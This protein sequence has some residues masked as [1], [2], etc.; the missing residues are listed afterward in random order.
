MRAPTVRLRI[1]FSDY[2]SGAIGCNPDDLRDCEPD[3]NG[4]AASCSDAE[5]VEPADDASA[6]VGWSGELQD[7]RQRETSSVER[8]NQVAQQQAQMR[9]ETDLG[10]VVNAI[11]ESQSK[12][13]LHCRK[14]RS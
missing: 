1:I 12:L 9:G 13:W 6:K 8:L 4:G 3:R 2:G 14:T 7:S 10:P 5:S 11:T